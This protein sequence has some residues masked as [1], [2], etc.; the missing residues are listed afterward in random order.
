M[1]PKACLDDRGDSIDRQ[2][3]GSGLERPHH[4]AASEYTQSTT[5]RT[6][7]AIGV[8]FGE[9]CEVCALGL[10]FRDDLLG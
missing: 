3:K 2:S 4:L 10:R 8:L 1:E 7:R 5:A 6:G 9:F